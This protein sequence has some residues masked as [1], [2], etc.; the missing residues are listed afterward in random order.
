MNPLWLTNFNSE[1]LVKRL[2]C[3][4]SLVFLLSSCLST[5]QTV[6]VLEGETNKPYE[7]L[8][9]VEARIPSSQL[10]SL[11]RAKSYKKLLH[12][13]LLRKAVPLGAEALVRT[14]Y[15]PDLSSKNFPG[16]FVY[17]KAEMVR[18][19]KFPIEADPPAKS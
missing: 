8:G 17:A 13:E 14:E 4:W 7:S 1:V 10:F 6:Q 12:R 16:G 9:F 15:W 19:E 3:V 11:H 2:A 18:F 5:H